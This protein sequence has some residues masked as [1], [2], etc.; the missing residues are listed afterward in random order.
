MVMQTLYRRT[1]YKGETKQQT[2]QRPARTDAGARPR[3]AAVV[4]LRQPNNCM[5]LAFFYPCGLVVFELFRAASC[6]VS[7]QPVP[8]S[9]YALPASAIIRKQAVYI[10]N[11]R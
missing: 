7:G 3:R 8:V 9:L 2:K 6:C 1:Y 4:E 10:A 5:V 11:M